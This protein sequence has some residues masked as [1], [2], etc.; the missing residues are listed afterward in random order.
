MFSSCGWK[1]DGTFLD[2]L[3]ATDQNEAQAMTGPGGGDLH[4]RYKNIVEQDMLILF[5]SP[6]AKDHTVKVKI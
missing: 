2:S 1:S 6:L 3:E 4:E 5:S